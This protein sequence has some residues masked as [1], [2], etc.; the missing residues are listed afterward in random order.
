[1]EYKIAV[2]GD[3]G[4]FSGP[5]NL[6]RCHLFFFQNN[7]KD[8]LDKGKYSLYIEWDTLKE[9]AYGGYWTDLK[10]LNL[11]GYNYLSWPIDLAD[12]VFWTSARLS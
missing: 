9:G 11:E 3:F 2:P 6:G 5:K 12:L 10:H 8:A 7:E 4:A 1:M